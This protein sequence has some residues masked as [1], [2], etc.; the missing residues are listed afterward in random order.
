MTGQDDEAIEPNAERPNK[1]FQPIVELADGLRKLGKFLAEVKIDTAL[2]AQF[3]QTDWKAVQER[4]SNLPARSRE[5]VSIASAQGWFFNWQKSFK[6][7][8]RLI[9][10]LNSAKDADSVDEIMRS[11]YSDDIEGY[12]RVLTDL[13]PERK[14]AI[15]AAVTAHTSYGPKGYYLSIPVFLAQADGILSQISGIDMPM[16]TKDGSTKGGNWVNSQ[17]GGNKSAK[18]LL[19]QMLNLHTMDI[20]KSQRQRDEDSKSGKTFSALNRH[21][22]LHG[23]VSNYGTE[24]NSL[25]AFSLLVF[26][27]AH[28]PDIL[29]TARSWDGDLFDEEEV[30]QEEL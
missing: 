17:I 29:E 23:E 13:Y 9:E 24:L 26:I 11:Y 20:L 10:S 14:Q 21:Q 30:I 27:G 18:Q 2:L 4:L 5:A 12:T 15:E 16:S 28:V 7:T 3:V 25:K 19:D 1:Q 22:V 8:W 6:E